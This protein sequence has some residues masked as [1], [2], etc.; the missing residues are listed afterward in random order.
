MAGHVFST[1]VGAIVHD[2]YGDPR[3]N[4]KVD[5]ETG[6]VTKSILCAPIRTVKE[7]EI[8]GVLQML[9]KKHGQFTAEHLR[10]L[11]DMTTLTAMALRSRQFVER[12]HAAREQEMRFLD[13]VADVTSDIDLG[14]MLRRKW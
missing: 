11:E 5:Q 7:S 9:N 2:P 6:Y 4:S 1:G 10:L 12:M 3:F 13:V 8:I 14:T